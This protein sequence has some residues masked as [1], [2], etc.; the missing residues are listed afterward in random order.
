MLLFVRDMPLLRTHTVDVSICL[1]GGI[2]SNSMPANLEKYL[3][4]ISPEERKKLFGDMMSVLKYPRGHPIREG[5]IL[6]VFHPNFH[7][8]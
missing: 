2:W 7:T 6:G 8:E 1:A 4:S 3:P 5:V